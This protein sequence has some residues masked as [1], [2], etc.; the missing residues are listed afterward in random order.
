MPSGAFVY[1]WTADVLEIG[2]EEGN[3]ML[4]EIPD[5]GN[6]IEIVRQVLVEG[7]LHYIFLFF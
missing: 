5:V 3:V 2:S 7:I 4:D 6:E 1:D